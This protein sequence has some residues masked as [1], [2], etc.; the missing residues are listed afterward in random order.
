MSDVSNEPPTSTLLRIYENLILKVPVLAVLAVAGVCAFFGYYTKDFGFD[1]SSEAIVLENDPDLRYYRESRETFGSDD[2][3]FLAITPPLDAE[4]KSLLFSEDT[5]SKFGRLVRELQDMENVES[6]TSI[7]NVPLF[8]SPHIPLME[9]A[10]GKFNTLLSEDCDLDLAIVELTESPLYSD[11]LISKDGGTTAVQVTFKEPAQEYNDLYN[12]RAELRDLDRTEGLSKDEAAE[13]T[14]VELRYQIWHDQ[15]NADGSE[16]IEKIRSIIARYD[17]IGDIHLGGV[18][19]VIADIISY[20][21]NDIYTLGIGVLLLVLLTLTVLFRKM[22]WIVLPT[23]TCLLTVLCM[24]GYLGFTNWRATIVTS[25][26]P[27]LLIV[28][29]MAM[30]MHI[31]VR[32]REI[33]ARNPEMSNRAIVL[34]TV[35]RVALPCLFTSLTTIVG[36]GS[37]LVSGMRPVMDFGIIMGIGIC[38]AYVL[39][40]VFLPAALLFFP[41]GKVPPAKLAELG[42]SPITVFAR[43]TE[44][45]GVLIWVGSAVIMVVSAIGILRL[46]VENSFIDYFDESTEIRRGMTVIDEKLGGT[47]PLEVVLV[48]EGKNYWLEDENRAKLREIHTWLDELPETG[49]VISPDTMIRILEGVNDGQ[50]V[51]KA[52]IT[53]ALNSIPDELTRAV[54]G[55]YATPDFDQV[56]I[57]MR[58]RESNR[59]LRRNELLKTIHAYLDGNESLKENTV[60]VTGVFVLYNNLLQSLFQSQIKTIGTV[61]VAIWLMFLMLFRS[62]SLATIAIIPNI[63]PVVVVLGAL[64]WF[65]IPLDMMTIMIAAITLGIAVDFAIHY[66]HRF[67]EEYAK[68]GDYV[69]CMH[70]CHSS[71][72]RAIS[73]TSITI[74]SGFTVLALSNFVP[75]VYFG[76]FTSLAMVVAMLAAL[77]LLPLLLITWK[78][79]G[80]EK[81]PTS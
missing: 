39:C 6:V 47:T 48:G 50:P 52:F 42:K 77:T 71:I 53:L 67:K 3:V 51:P 34:E 64:G 38:V 37:L 81:V 69:A 66:I 62:F 60:H 22:K 24:I 16:V 8:H 4:G 65:N 15:L 54:V 19:M 79:L 41:K 40:F 61:F 11:Y 57:A 21:E 23:A 27:S 25:N 43:F 55:P 10:T 13:L 56:R 32:Y 76:L 59:D 80:K 72:G 68:D 14:D 28:I 45:R 36:F 78:P 33:Y 73:Y 35:R 46:E 74:V 5:L 20:V 30:A 70:R 2:Y 7:L 12:R 63:L 18:P 44:R 31:A 29:T 75:S 17:D 58:V 26:F 1:A 9:L 49:K